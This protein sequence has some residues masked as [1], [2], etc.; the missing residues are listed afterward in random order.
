MQTAKLSRDR[1]KLEVEFMREVGISY[2]TCLNKIRNH[3]VKQAQGG[4]KEQAKFARDT[5]TKIASISRE[6]VPQ[7][8][9]FM[10][11]TSETNGYASSGSSD[12]TFDNGN[13]SICLSDMDASSYSLPRKKKGRPRKVQPPSPSSAML[14]DKREMKR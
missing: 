8:F 5:L 9:E 13:S 6:L 4:S 12:R 10:Y 1:K 11:H 2:L 3:L 7:N 14:E